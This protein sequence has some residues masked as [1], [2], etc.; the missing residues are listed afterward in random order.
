ME[1]EE[2]VGRGGL[3]V[4][5]CASSARNRIDQMFKPWGAAAQAAVVAG[6][7]EPPSRPCVVARCG[8]PPPRPAAV[9]RCGEPPRPSV[10]ARR[11]V[12]PPTRQPSSHA[13]G[14]CRRSLPSPRGARGGVCSGVRRGLIMAFS[15]AVEWWEEWQLRIL[16]LSSL[17]L[18]Y[19][20]FFAAAL[21]KR[22]IP[23]WFRFLT[24]LAYLSTDAITIYALATL[25]NRHKEDWSSTHRSRATLEVVWAPILLLHLGGQDGIT[26]YNIEDNELWRRHVL[27]AVSQ[28][29]V[30]IYVFR[31]SWSGG[32]KRLLQAAILTFVPGV[33]KCLEKPIALRSASI[34]SVDNSTPT[35]WIA[36]LLTG[37]A[38]EDASIKSLDKYVEAASAVVAEG[39]QDNTYTTLN[40]RPYNLFVDLA[41]TYTERL[42]NLKYMMKHEDEAHDELR[43]LLSKSFDRLY[44]KSEMSKGLNICEL[45]CKSYWGGSLRSVVVYLTFA[46]IGL[47]HKSH[48][49]NYDGTDVKITYTLLCCTA[50]LEYI[51]SGIMPYVNCFY[52]VTTPPWPDLVAQYSLFG[53]L[54]R[55]KKHRRFR[56]FLLDG[57][58]AYL[59]EI[60]P[61]K[62][63][64]SS[65]DITKLVYDHVI[66]GWKGIENLDT[67]FKFN[68]SRGQWTLR[69]KGANSN[70]LEW[71]LQQ[72]AFDESVLLW[73]LATDFCFHQ[74]KAEKPSFHGD[75]VVHRSRHISNYM[76]YL[77]FTNPE[78]LMAGS[79]RSLFKDAYKVL[80][81]LVEDNASSSPLC[82]DE[83][84]ST[85]IEKMNVSKGSGLVLEAW[86]LAQQLRD[87]VMVGAEGEKKMWEL[88]Q[89][90]WVEMICFSA[91]R[92]HGYLHAKS[93]GKGGEYLS[94]VWML[95]SYMGMETLAERLQRTGLDSN[96]KGATR[97]M[98]SATASA[99]STGNENNV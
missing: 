48:R 37:D 64:Q 14:C 26:A 87:T 88:I 63:C 19:F 17:L 75:E 30:A 73:H 65:K 95:L 57:I 16:V 69:N 27:T 40:D 82:E 91:G 80:K 2:A 23:D 50:A 94:Y 39:L 86:G 51:S 18:Q 78:M 13:E 77:L 43:S 7:A 20:L 70:V 31:K 79:R 12:L 55:N 98:T 4:V 49:E 58:K 46:A 41:N 85:I 45:S 81:E 54:A 34:K 93:L 8:V 74:M 21:R 60:W 96:S 67:Y 59:D 15:D 10:I 38:E 11:G 22:H 33:L 61:M 84:A 6:R 92:C 47:F 44:T 36:T 99:M 35:S 56:S 32:D 52:M 29:T 72:R 97:R 83:L 9:A 62:P 3:A 76:A 1:I 89:G 42:D 25:F 53:Y 28:I 90:V 71:S 24:W 68:D 66:Q 5:A